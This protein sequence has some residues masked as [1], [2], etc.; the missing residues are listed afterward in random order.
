MEGCDLS[1]I[2]ASYNTK[3]LLLGC[4]QS[5]YANTQ[6]IGYEVIVVDDCSEDGSP[7]MVSEAF[8]QVRL[9]CNPT[10]LRY[11][12]TNNT[13]L[14]VAQGRYAL[15]LNSD[16]EVQ[17]GALAALVEFMDAHSDA[18]V[19]GPKLINPDGSVQHCIRSFPSLVPMIFQ[20]LSLHKI[21]PNNPITNRYYNVDFDYSK[22]QTVQSI[23][24]TS[25]IIRRSVWETYGLLD[26]RLT[27]SFVD[28][29]YC[30]ML[31][32]H[33]QNIYYVPQAVVLHYG[34]QTINQNGLKEIRLLHEE[35][36][37]FYD[38]YLA[39]KHNALWRALIHA[40]IWLRER[41][42]ILEF[43]YTGDKRVFST[44]GVSATPRN[45]DT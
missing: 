34:G 7:K 12:K 31:G 10:N 29:S 20:S 1:V 42:K 24:T 43:K 44:P 13:G 5:I 9:I 35:L 33:K 22:V 19:A 18:A 16:V 25:F 21:W 3:A 15:L 14:R 27:L 39:P 6:G 30:Y 37:K 17:P 8:P 41:I 23:G 36:G 45:Q 28:L 2:V 26:E 4:L 40:G 32:Q 38:F 11:A